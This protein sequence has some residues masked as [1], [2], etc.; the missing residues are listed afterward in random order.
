MKVS[1]SKLNKLKRKLDTRPIR[2]ITDFKYCR[3]TKGYDQVGNCLLCELSEPIK[4]TN[5]YLSMYEIFKQINYRSKLGERTA[6]INC[7]GEAIK[8]PKPN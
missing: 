8:C 5:T 4:Q 6:I 2:D 1:Q 3:K 7:R